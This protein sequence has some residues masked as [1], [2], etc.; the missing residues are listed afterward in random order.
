MPPTNST[1]DENNASWT[2]FIAD[3]NDDNGL[4]WEFSDRSLSSTFMDMNITIQP[5]GKLKTVLYEKPMALYRFIP[6]HSAH[7]PGVLTS[8]VFGNILR[9]FRLNSDKED[10]I[11]DSVTFFHGFLERG[12]NCVPIFSDGL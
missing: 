10:V 2:A 9:V 5:D 8:H 1:N 12:H 7:P 3:A 6:P 4:E 11:Q